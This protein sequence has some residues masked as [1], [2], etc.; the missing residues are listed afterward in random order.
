MP[1][2]Y[3]DEIVFSKNTILKR[4]YTNKYTHLTTDQSEYYIK[5]CCAIVAVNATMGLVHY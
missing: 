2:V 1:I 4:A 3:L 5:Y